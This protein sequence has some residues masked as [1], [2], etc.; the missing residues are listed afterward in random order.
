MMSFTKILSIF[1]LI[2]ATTINITIGQMIKQCVCSEIQ[3]CLGKFS[4]SVIV[5][6]DQC[7]HHIAKTGANYQALRSCI[8]SKEPMIKS[9]IKCQNDKL[10]DTCAKRPGNMVKKRYEETI[11]IAA[12]SEIN[13]MLSSSGVLSQVKPLL[14]VGKKFYGCV[15]KCMK[16][17]AGNC[18]DNCGLDLPSDTVMVQQTK[19][20]AKASGFSTP[21]VRDLC[22]CAVKAGLSQLNG[23]CDKIVIS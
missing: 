10:S 1:L 13:K 5:C 23:V 15:A 16:S 21:V 9:T 6:A 22:G 20:C 12:I 18:Q 8:L 3:P 11:K 14:G 7:Q 2:A 19:Q 4:D 17:K